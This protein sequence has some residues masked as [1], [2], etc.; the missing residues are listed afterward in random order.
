MGS[1]PIKSDGPQDIIGAAVA[2][3]GSEMSATVPAHCEDIRKAFESYSELAVAAFVDRSDDDAL[4]LFQQDLLDVGVWRREGS[5]SVRVEFVLAVGGPTV[6]VKV[7][8]SDNVTFCHS[9]GWNS[10]RGCEQ[11]E[12]ELF[13]GSP[14][15]QAW[16]AA[17]ELVGGGF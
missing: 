5:H 7:D 12:L 1:S 3:S 10:A 14:E 2:A 16:A 15:A 9:W 4:E 13:G 6:R 17:A 11:K 8:E